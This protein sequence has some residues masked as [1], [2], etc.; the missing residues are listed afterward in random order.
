MPSLV[1]IGERA[2]RNGSVPPYRLARVPASAADAKRRRT[3][4]SADGDPG[5]A[6]G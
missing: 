5:T 1:W 3:A 2:S 6:F 4:A